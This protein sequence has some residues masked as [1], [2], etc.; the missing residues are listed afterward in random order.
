MRPSIIPQVYADTIANGGGTFR[1]DGSHVTRGYSVAVM[2]DFSASVPRLW[3]Q[4][5]RIEGSFAIVDVDDR[6]AFEQAVNDMYA[7]FGDRFLGTW[8]HEGRIHIDPVYVT[9]RKS[10][11]HLIALA[12]NQLAYYDLTEQREVFVNG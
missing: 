3:S 8:V 2:D 7:T 1:P 12:Y 10:E 9:S 4:P 5:S 6:P 11:A